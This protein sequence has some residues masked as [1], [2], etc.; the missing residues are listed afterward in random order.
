MRTVTFHDHNTVRADFVE[1]RFARMRSFLTEF[2]KK[3][4]EASPA[5]RICCD[6]QNFKKLLCFVYF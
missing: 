1:D 6:K 4:E 2:E 3:C 5:Y